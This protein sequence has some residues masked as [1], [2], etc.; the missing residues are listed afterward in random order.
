MV[1][2]LVRA[3]SEHAQEVQRESGRCKSSG[4]SQLACPGRFAGAWKWSGWTGLSWAGVRRLR[5]L[6]MVE[7][8]QAA[9]AFGLDSFAGRRSGARLREGDPVGESWM[10]SFVVIVGDVF[11]EG[12]AQGAFAEGNPQGTKP[13][14]GSFGRF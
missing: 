3:E 11:F 9:Q 12:V 14:A 7:L 10:V 6:A 5:G 8:E 2:K 1:K 13:I 4:K